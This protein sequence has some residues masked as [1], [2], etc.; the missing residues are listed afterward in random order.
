MKSKKNLAALAALSLA[1]TLAAAAPASSGDKNQSG[2]ANSSKPGAKDD[3]TNGEIR[4]VDKANKGL[5]IR[6]EDIKNLQM[7]GMTMP[8]RVKQPSMLDGLKDGDKIRFR[9]EQAGADLVV[10]EIHVIK[11]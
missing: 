11:P 6:H 1:V 4:R 10:T 9:A 8:F 2:S 5:I 3:L 7:P